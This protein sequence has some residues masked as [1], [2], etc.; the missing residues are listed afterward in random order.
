MGLAGQE[1]FQP[2]ICACPWCCESLA[3]PRH[4]PLCPGQGAL[5][6]PTGTSPP[7]SV[8]QPWLLLPSHQPWLARSEPQH[9]QFCLST[10]HWCWR[11]PSLRLD[12]PPLPASPT[13]GDCHFC[14]GGHCPGGARGGRIPAHRGHVS[15]PKP[16]LVPWP[17]PRVAPDP[18]GCRQPC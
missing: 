13:A 12:S 4:F 9:T 2:L 7:L 6:C 17:R 14:P 18:T 8:H 11:M 1:T 3:L 16:P 10:Q 5:S 15:L